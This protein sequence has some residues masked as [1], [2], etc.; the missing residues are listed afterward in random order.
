MTNK[1]Y[2][3]SLA[4]LQNELYRITLSRFGPK[5]N[6][7]WG[8]FHHANAGMLALSFESRNRARVKEEADFPLKER[9]DETN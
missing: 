2:V 5:P 3:N 9:V 8:H 4:K 6:N 7:A 1:E